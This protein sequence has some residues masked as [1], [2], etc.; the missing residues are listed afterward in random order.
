[1]VGVMGAIR[2]NLLHGFGSRGASTIT[3]QLIGMMY[4]A[5][6]DRREISLGRKL[7]EAR[8]ERALERRHSKSE[9]LEAYLN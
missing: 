9:I 2:D 5:E 4:P 8:M 7:R 6:V 1:V 3:Q